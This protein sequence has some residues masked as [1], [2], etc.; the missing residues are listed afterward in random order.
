MLVGS[1]CSAEEDPP[2]QG[3]QPVTGDSSYIWLPPVV[4]A[5]VT[6]APP[7]V[8]TPPIVVTNPTDRLFG[9]FTV[10]KAVTGATEGIVDPSAPYVMNW[11][12][13]D[14]SGNQYDGQL[15]VPLGGTRT[16][17]PSEQ[18]PAGSECTLDEPLAD[19]PELVD[20]AWQ[21]QDPTFTVDGVPA[22]G[23]WS[24]ARL[25]DP[26]PAGGRRRS[27]TWPSASPTPSPGPPGPSRWP[28]PATRR[29]ARV[30]QPGLG[31]HLHGHVDV[32]RH[33][34]RCTMSS[35]PTISPVSW[36]TP[37]WSM[38]R[39]WRRPARRRWSA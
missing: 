12:C 34:A 21:W 6:I 35:S 25:H 24:D 20:D 3:G 29:R 9:T 16:V 31:R 32:D 33:G 14:G 13:V 38:A 19:M 37:P 17:G 28:R 15:E 26:D 39:S 23:D 10:T 4:S 30:V 2:G 1:V 36:P 5:P 11:A 8:A 7:A 22:V 18:L 27:R